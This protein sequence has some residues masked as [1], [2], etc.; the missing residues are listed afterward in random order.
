MRQRTSLAWAILTILLA[1][2]TCGGFAQIP[3]ASFESWEADADTNF[4][5]VGWQTTNSYPVV[6]VDRVSPGCQ[7][8]YAMRVKTVNVGIA[9]PGVAILQIPYAFSAVPT[10]FSA[11]IRSNIVGGDITYII[12]GLMKG[13]S[14]IASVD[15]CT[16]KIDTTYSQFTTRQFRIASHST[17]VPDSLVIIIASGLGTGHVGTEL[18]VD[19][20]AFG[21]GGGTYVTNEE[22][23]PRVF[24]L[25]QNFPN[26]FNPTTVIRYQLP[27]ASSVK[28]IV[29]D[30]LGREVAVLV[31]ETKVPGSYE[32]TYDASKLSSGVYFYGLVGGD[33]VQTRKMLVVK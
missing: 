15:S 31:N 2:S 14:V 12:L 23:V 17:L 9:F 11:C 21:T 20:I 24:A 10:Q 18:I 13:D 25:H 8:N 28:L 6:T 16:F 26:P 7:G 32:V 1:M 33:F 22:R 4:N 5:P 19:E 3:N 27:V 30:I 29:Y